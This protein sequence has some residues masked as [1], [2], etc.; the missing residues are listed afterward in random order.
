MQHPY[1]K[2]YISLQVFANHI[3]LH[4]G[5]YKGFYLALMHYYSEIVRLPASSYIQYSRTY[6]YSYI[7]IIASSIVNYQ[8]IT[9]YNIIAIIPQ[10]H[11]SM[12]MTL[13][14]Q[15]WIR[16]YHH[17]SHQ[18]YNVVWW[19]SQGNEPSK[20]NHIGPSKYLFLAKN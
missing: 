14:S 15:E 3:T 2:Y 10:N 11:G 16:S 12:L 5:K 17:I 18:V 19:C 9:H 6:T 7:W 13:V 1:I 20:P 4:F 8:Y